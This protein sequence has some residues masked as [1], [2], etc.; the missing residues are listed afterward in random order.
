MYTGSFLLE[1]SAPWDVE[2]FL[3]FLPF[4]LHHCLSYSF[5]MLALLFSMCFIY[6]NF[7]QSLNKGNFFHKV[8]QCHNFLKAHGFATDVPMQLYAMQKRGS[9]CQAQKNS[10][11]WNWTTIK[12]LRSFSMLLYEQDPF[13]AILHIWCHKIF[14]VLK[15]C[16]IGYALVVF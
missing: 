8:Q 3:W 10:F 4:L 11:A 5:L 14:D 6:S 15:S 2:L 1:N 13:F 7:S 12:A 16:F 9:Q